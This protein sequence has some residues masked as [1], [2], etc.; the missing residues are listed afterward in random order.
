MSKQTK[1]T[2]AKKASYTTTNN[3]HTQAR[4]AKPTTDTQQPNNGLITCP[5]CKQPF[6]AKYHTCPRICPKR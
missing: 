4:P 5:T 1:Q 3:T 6:P 2:N